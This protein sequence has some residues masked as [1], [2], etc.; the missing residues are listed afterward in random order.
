MMADFG[1]WLETHIRTRRRV[2]IAVHIKC[3]PFLL[4]IFAYVAVLVSS[5]TLSAQYTYAVLV[6][7]HSLFF[8]QDKN[9]VCGLLFC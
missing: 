4:V 5:F 8:G 2:A 3:S 6:V 9:S 7:V 1:F